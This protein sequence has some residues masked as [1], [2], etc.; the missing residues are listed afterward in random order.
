MYGARYK[1]VQSLGL[2]LVLSICDE[3]G[4]REEIEVINLYVGLL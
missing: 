3:N 1:C 2:E 4:S